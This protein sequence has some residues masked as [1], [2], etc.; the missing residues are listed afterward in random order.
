M[1]EEQN[2]TH[3]DSDHIA[4]IPLPRWAWSLDRE[5]CVRFNLTSSPPNWFYRKMLR[6]FFGVHTKLLTENEA[7]EEAARCS[8][9][10]GIQF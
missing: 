1:S 4:L 2:Q 3:K 10:K 8:G 9:I 6:W 7:I 5:F